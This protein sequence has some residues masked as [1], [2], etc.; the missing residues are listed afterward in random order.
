MTLKK[1]AICA[2]A[3]VA[4]TIASHLAQAAGKGTPNHGVSTSAPGHNTTSQPGDPGKSGNSPGDLK[5]D[6]GDANAKGFAP[7]Q[8]NPNK[9]KK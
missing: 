8:N 7:G 4:A 1:V 5:N 6:A 2:T 9:N 3:L